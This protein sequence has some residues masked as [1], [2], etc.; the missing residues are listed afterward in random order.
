MTSCA[1]APAGSVDAW[2]KEQVEIQ[3]VFYGVEEGAGF[4]ARVEA[5]IARHPGELSAV[6]AAAYE[7]IARAL[8]AVGAADAEVHPPHRWT[9]EALWERYR[10]SLPLPAG[11]L[12]VI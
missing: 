11:P 7:A 3:G 6:V 9:F 2:F 8:A 4:A 10:A 5:T 12:A 1:Y